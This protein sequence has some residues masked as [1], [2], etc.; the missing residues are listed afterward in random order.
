MNAARKNQKKASGL[1]I[2]AIV[3]LVAAVFARR[4]L[5]MTGGVRP[6]ARSEMLASSSDPVKRGEAVYYKHCS[7][8]HSPDTDDTT[9]GPTLKNYFKRPPTKL[10][11]GTVFPRADAA[12]RDLL[13]HGTR[14]MPPISQDLSEQ[15][16]ADVLAFMHTL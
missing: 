1:L 10:S 6:R 15:D 13:Q 14:D 11:N 16:T 5:Q 8:C 2:A 7:V 3:L 4:F 9:V 12:I